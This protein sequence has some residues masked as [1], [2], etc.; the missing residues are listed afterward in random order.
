MNTP[1]RRASV[2]LPRDESVKTPPWS[3]TETEAQH[4]LAVDRLEDDE[5]KLQMER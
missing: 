2:R 5:M 1:G 3:S 4:F